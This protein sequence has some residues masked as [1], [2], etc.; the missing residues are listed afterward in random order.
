[1]KK[2]LAFTM[3]LLFFSPV[4][5]Q[6]TVHSMPEPEEVKIAPY[7]ST[8]N[9]LG[10]WGAE[11]YTGQILYVVGKPSSLRKYGYDNF[12]SK[13]AKGSGCLYGVE[14]G[15]FATGAPYESLAGKYFIV[16]SVEEIGAYT[17]RY[18][19]MLENRDKA[20]DIAWFYYYGEYEHAFPFIV[21]SHFDYLK[22]RYIG[23]EIIEFSKNTSNEYEVQIKKCTDI[24][25]EDRY[26]K[27]SIFFDD[28]ELKSV[29][30]DIDTNPGFGHLILKEKYLQLIKMYDIETVDR[31]MK[32]MISVGM[33]K[34]LLLLSWGE[35]QRINSNSYDD[36][37]QWVYDSQYVYVKNGIVSAWSD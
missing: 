23:K 36:T 25:I 31:A 18:W 10:K 29:D 11:T 26:Y 7:D 14:L 19:F 22:Q 15:T 4:F 5:S 3:G 32:H 20:E 16:K 24:G 34:E 8:K 17:G 13:K 21:L 12:Y 1:M 37:E 35:P 33:A 28:G 27:L 2:L 9:F 6:I 30:N